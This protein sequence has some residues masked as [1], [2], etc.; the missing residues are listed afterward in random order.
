[1]IVQWARPYS[2]AGALCTLPPSAS[3]SELHAVADAQHG[4]AELE[5]F[6]IALRRAGF[7]DARRPAGEDEPLR[8]QLANPLRP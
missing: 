3:Q 4:N 1:M 7:V 5:K 6:R 8:G 2:R